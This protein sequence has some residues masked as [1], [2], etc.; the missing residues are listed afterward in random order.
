MPYTLK[1]HFKYTVVMETQPGLPYSQVRDM[2]SKKLELLPEHTRLRWVH[3]QRGCSRGPGMGLEER[4]EFALL[5][6][7]VVLTPVSPATGLGTAMSW[8]PSRK[9]T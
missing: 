6:S 8:C 4:R 5:F 1:V 3:P 2:V 9:R 7:D